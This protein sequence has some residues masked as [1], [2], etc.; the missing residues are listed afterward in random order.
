MSN[1]T[2]E[3]QM[4]IAAGTFEYEKHNIEMARQ[5]FA[6][7]IKKHTDNKTLYLELFWIELMYLGDVEGG[8]S[9]ELMAI[10]LYKS[11]INK[12]KQDME[13]HI[14]LL[15]R[16]IEVKPIRKLQCEIIWYLHNI[17]D[18]NIL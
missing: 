3:P 17:N 4:Y 15:N 7:G 13:F 12:F 18:S 9:H 11:I 14:I 6:E 16:S 10:K 8:E 5:Y 1:K 2:C